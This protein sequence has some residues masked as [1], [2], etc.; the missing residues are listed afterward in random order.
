CELLSIREVEK[1]PERGGSV[2]AQHLLESTCLEVLLCNRLG[3]LRQGRARE[4]G[5]DHARVVVH[6]QR[7]RYADINRVTTVLHAPVRENPIGPAYPNAGMPCKI[8][9]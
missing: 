9:G 7:T 8:R 4:R 5:V 6:D 1:N 3:H 2:F